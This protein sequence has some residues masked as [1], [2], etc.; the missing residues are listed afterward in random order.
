MLGG[1]I[2]ACAPAPPSTLWLPCLSREL[3]RGL[4]KDYSS[5]L[6]TL[7]IQ[8]S[9][10]WEGQGGAAQ[11]GRRT[12]TVHK[13]LK[14]RTEPEC[15]FCSVGLA[16]GAGACRIVFFIQNVHSRGLMF[17]V[18]VQKMIWAYAVC[19]NGVNQGRSHLDKSGWNPGY[20]INPTSWRS[21]AKPFLFYIL[22]GLGF[23]KNWDLA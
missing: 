16:Q 15:G 9:Q 8:G 4:L 22:W 3:W 14:H 10:P 20:K 2:W 11:E 1:S 19:E 6:G 21:I 5:W 23:N 12:H 18:W 13:L 17:I 7:I